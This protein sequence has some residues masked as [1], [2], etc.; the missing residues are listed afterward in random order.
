MRIHF[1]LLLDPARQLDYDLAE[2]EQAIVDTTQDWVDRLRDRLIE[3]HGEEYGAE[4]ADRFGAGFP[5][6]YRDEFDPRVAVMD[7]GRILAV[8]RGRSIEMSFY[9]M[10][11]E[12][13]QH[14][15][16]RLFRKGESLPLSDVLPVLENL[17]L[18]VI[19]ESPYGV[20]EKDGSARRRA[21]ISTGCCSAHS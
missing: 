15:R 17:G 20:R 18:R 16:F 21:I 11:D 2:L 4:Y 7:L 9:R 1:V 10:V 13:D 6:G 12:E 5:A 3:E 19:A 14:L 8:S